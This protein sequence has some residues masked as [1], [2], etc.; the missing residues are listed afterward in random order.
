MKK[1]LNIQGMHCASCANIITKRVKKIPGVTNIDVNI[2][3]DTA[4]LEFDSNTVTLD[5][6]NT[7]VREL[8][9]SFSEE[10]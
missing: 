7:T 4:T 2:S 10:D 9:Y 8:G 6:I 5:T 3:T 1:R